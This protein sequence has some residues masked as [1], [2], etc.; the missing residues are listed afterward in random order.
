M[1]HRAANTN[2]P[3]GA[4]ATSAQVMV[5]SRMAHAP[6]RCLVI[7]PRHRVH[8]SARLLAGMIEALDRR[9]TWLMDHRQD[10]AQAPDLLRTAPAGT[11][12]GGIIFAS[13]PLR[14]GLLRN[15]PFPVVLP[16]IASDGLPAITLDE[17]GIGAL[18]GRHLY[19]PGWAGVAVGDL[20]APWHHA[21][22]AGWQSTFPGA[23]QVMIGQDDAA[24]RA[25]WHAIPRHTA[26][27][28]T[29]D[30]LAAR[31]TRA[32]VDLG[33]RPGIDY[34][35]VGVDDDIDARLQHP[36]TSSIR[37]PLEEIGRLAVEHL[38]HRVS[39]QTIA[40][41]PPLGPQALMVR[42]TSDP[43]LA[44]EPWLQELAGY[45]HMAVESGQV[46]TVERLIAGHG[47]S[48]S[49]I[50]RAWRAATGMGILATVQRWQIQILYE[51]WP[52]GGDPATI[53]RTLGLSGPRALARLRALPPWPV[54]IPSS[55]DRI[56]ARAPGAPT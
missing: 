40:D 38:A 1:G 5:D 44:C 50:E 22:V 2:G 55:A 12:D 16:V 30:P 3:D 52:E 31:L 37:L 43:F 21:R 54:T 56:P 10:D 34:C 20:D 41:P 53:A 7:V 42:E 17:H 35:L 48:R 14:D 18:A 36:T 15:L 32:A 26:V 29:T 4:P 24:A 13:S 27:F 51:R 39:G 11:W 23:R 45:A 8:F 25:F 19:R 6:F 33:L 28:A 46:A 49:T 9:P 47:R